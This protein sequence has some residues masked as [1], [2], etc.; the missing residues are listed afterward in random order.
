MQSVRFISIKAFLTSAHAFDFSKSHCLGLPGT[1]HLD[2]QLYFE[3]HIHY[4]KQ[5]IYKSVTPASITVKSRRCL[6]CD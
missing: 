1:S 3:S 2:A 6:I 5:E 4:A